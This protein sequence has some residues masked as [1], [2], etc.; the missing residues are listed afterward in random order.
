[1]NN[2]ITQQLPAFI[3]LGIA[4]TLLIG[5]FIVTAYI[6]FWGILLGS[7]LWLCL[8]LKSC[9]TSQRTQKKGRIIDYE[10]FK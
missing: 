7:V 10:D 5:L 2:K 8:F 3:I 1:M 4:I 9:F 6:I